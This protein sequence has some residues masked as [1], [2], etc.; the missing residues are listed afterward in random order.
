MHV[1]EC[2][3]GSGCNFMIKQLS[4]MYKSLVSVPKKGKEKGRGGE[5]ETGEGTKARA[6]QEKEQFMTS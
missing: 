3:L 2:S 5:G 1:R 6:P 4:V